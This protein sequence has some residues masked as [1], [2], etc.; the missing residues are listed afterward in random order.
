LPIWWRRSPDVARL[1]PRQRWSCERSD[2]AYFVNVGRSEAPFRN[3]GER[4]WCAA[5]NSALKLTGLRPE[6]V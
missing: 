4:F 2:T 1:G 5:A 3:P 6:L